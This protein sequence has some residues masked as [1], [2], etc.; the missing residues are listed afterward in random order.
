[1]RAAEESLREIAAACT[2]ITALVGVPWFND[3]LANACAV[4]ADGEVPA[5]YRKRLLPNYGVF[6]EERYFAPGTEAVCSRSRD[7]GSA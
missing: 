3:D 1:M 4:C 2:E 6:D 7:A 5:I